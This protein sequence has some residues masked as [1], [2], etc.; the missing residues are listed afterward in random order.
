LGW[1]INHNLLDESTIIRL[2]QQFNIQGDENKMKKSIKITVV[3]LLTCFAGI[4]TLHGQGT[5]I[6]FPQSPR[7]DC[8]FWLKQN[9]FVLK[10]GVADSSQFK[11]FFSPD[12][13]VIQSVK[14]ALGLIV[15]NDL[16][17]NSFKKMTIKWGVNNY[18]SGANWDNGVHNE[19]IMVYVFFGDQLYSSDSFFIPNS[20]PFIGFYLG[21]HDKI[22]GSHVGRHF[23]K[24]G[25]YICMAN[26]PIGHTVTSE[27]DL[28]AEF[29]KAFGNSI[30]MPS[31]I[32]GISIESDT[33]DLPA[34]S[35]SS[36]FIK[37]IDITN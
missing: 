26:P 32:S 11:L 29:K 6:N 8:Y 23:T 10:N 5:T 27:I 28:V 25:R 9:G 24:G 16:N 15:K 2:N 30:P 22:G 37:S 13:L 20:P 33:S 31:F 19:P 14:P 3:A 7:Q 1:G 34:K 18:P 4:V 21:R 35:L 12:G 17:I 36:A